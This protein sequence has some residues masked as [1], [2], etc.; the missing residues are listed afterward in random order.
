[1]NS[2]E[3]TLAT[4]T[5]GKADFGV[6]D[7][8]PVMPVPLMQGALIYDCTVEDY[9]N[10]PAMKLAD[11][12]VQLNQMLNGVPD[13]VAGIPNV[14]QDTTAFGIDMVY[15]YE[16]SS[17]GLSGMLINSL[18]DLPRLRTPNPLN[19]PTLVKTLDTISALK[20]K[21][22]SEKIVVG[23]CVAPFSLPSLLMGTERWMKL[24]MTPKLRNRYLKQVLEVCE[25]FVIGWANAQLHAGAHL[26][27]L[28]DGMASATLL[29]KPYF[30]QYALPVIK[31]TISRING[32]VGYEA[33]GKAEPFIDD[34]ANIG[35]VVLLLGEEDNIA[36][37]KK[38]CGTRVGLMGNINNMKLRRWSAARVELVAKAALNI[39]KPGYGYILANQGPEIPFDTP[40]ENIAALVQAA[41][42]YGYYDE[43][44]HGQSD[45]TLSN[46]A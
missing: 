45:M 27:V 30:Q 20:T 7:R 32:F 15:S 1:M 17:P 9:F 44:D 34:L 21:I 18:D 6:P 19:S 36:N 12:Q 43:Q 29:P 25:T 16:N 41:E 46:A 22:G 24:L 2:I 4:L 33:V 3:R 13:A 23:A 35:A 42:R 37:C 40:V 26:V 14:I 5:F 31:R 38:I 8:V 11:A 39:G 28:A 10:M